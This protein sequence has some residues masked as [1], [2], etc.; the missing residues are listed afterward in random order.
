MKYSCIYLYSRYR[1]GIKWAQFAY[2]CII[3]AVPLISIQLI[4]CDSVHVMLLCLHIPTFAILS[5][6][7]QLLE[8]EEWMCPPLLFPHLTL[9]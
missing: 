3:H 5:F 4:L 8:I 6:S 1:V 2:N 9:L 7:P